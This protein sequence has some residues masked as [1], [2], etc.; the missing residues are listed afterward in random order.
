MAR[1]LSLGHENEAG[2]QKWIGLK[3][4]LSR[5]QNK[6]DFGIINQSKQH[7]IF[8]V[9]GLVCQGYGFREVVCF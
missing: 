4:K 9:E 5:F 8:V 2:M 6:Y 1:N 3:V 7:M